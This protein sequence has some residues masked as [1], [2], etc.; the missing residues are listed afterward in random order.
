MPLPTEHSARILNPAS[1]TKNYGRQ[2]LAPGIIRVACTL[3]A[4]PTKWATQSYRFKKSNF[5]AAEAKKWLKDH[6][7][8]YTLFEPASGD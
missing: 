8:K 7:V 3:K 1:C 6:D 5:T 4:N 2:T